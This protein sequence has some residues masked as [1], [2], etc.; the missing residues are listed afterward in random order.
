MLDEHAPNHKLSKK[1]ISLK[2]EPW[3]NKNIQSLMGERARLFK[4]YCNENDPTLMIAKHKKY[5]NA[6]DLVIFKIKKSKKE[7]YQNYFQKHSKNV[8]KTWDSIKSIVMLK[9]IDKTTPNSFN[10]NGNGITNK[11]CIAEIFSD[12]FVN[13]GSNL[14]SKIRKG[15]RT[16][17]AY[18]GLLQNLFLC[19]TD[20]LIL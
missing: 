17:N 16:F 6:R 2:A 7:Y 13:T 14:A 1:E 19:Q 15:K 3:I 10:V 12:F 9:Y 20:I 11:I 5:Q 8:K 18:L 4:R